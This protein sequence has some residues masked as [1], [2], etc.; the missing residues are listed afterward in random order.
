MTPIDFD[1]LD[2]LDDCGGYYL[3]EGK[4]FS[5]MAYEFDSDSDV[6]VGLMG[7]DRR[8]LSGCARTWSSSGVLLEEESREAQKSLAKL[9]ASL[10]A[11]PA[12]R[13]GQ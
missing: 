13:L 6:I 4:S 5:G 1:E 2:S 3:H 11:E 7:F 9:A 10:A 12:P 8:R